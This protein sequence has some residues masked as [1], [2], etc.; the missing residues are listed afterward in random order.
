LRLPARQHNRT[1]RGQDAAETAEQIEPE[2][3]HPVYLSIQ[4]AIKR[5]P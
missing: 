3:R 4:V 1:S 2:A 5:P